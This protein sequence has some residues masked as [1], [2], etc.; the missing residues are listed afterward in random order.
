MRMINT[1]T[2]RGCL[3]VALCSCFVTSVSG[4]DPLRA[5]QYKALKALP[6]IALLVHQ[7]DPSNNA[8]LIDSLG[9]GSKDLSNVVTI[10]LSKDIP[11]L[12]LPA[13]F[14][15]D[16]PYLEIGWY[17]NSTALVRLSRRTATGARVSARDLETQSY[18]RTGLLMTSDV[19][20]VRPLSPGSGKG[21]RQFGTRCATRRGERGCPIKRSRGR[22]PGS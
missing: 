2:A 8:S 19:T 17:G 4:Q 22:T 15:N 12:R 13:V 10:R 9:L 20:A 6:E 3:V 21:P 16:R 14:K 11:G 5:D 1:L 18:P 7:P